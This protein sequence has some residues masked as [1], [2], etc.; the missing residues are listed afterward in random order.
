[1]GTAPAGALVCGRKVSVPRQD[2]LR[3]GTPTVRPTGVGG[4]QWKGETRR[5]R[6]S[7][8]EVVSPFLTSIV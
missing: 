3:V 1:M 2:A 5:Q 6:V 4:V 8:W 7:L